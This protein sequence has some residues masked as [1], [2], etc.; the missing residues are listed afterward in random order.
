MMIAPLAG[1]GATELATLS[2]FTWPGFAVTPDG[3]HVLYARWERRDS[4]LMS[5]EY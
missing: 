4:N 5:I 2:Q 3:A 1:G